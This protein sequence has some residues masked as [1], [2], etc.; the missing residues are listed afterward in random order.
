[1]EIL[2]ASVPVSDL[3]SSLDWYERLFGRP[4][5]VVPNEDEVMWHVAGT[6]WLYVIQDVERAG[7]TVVT[8]SVSDLEQFVV[9]L[10]R[11]GI[12]VGPVE[13]H[14]DAGRKVDVQDPDG[15]VI[16]WIEVSPRR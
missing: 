7:K 13:S 1:M 9:D 4:P 15:N 2:F 12:S 11:R 10:E 3:H 5:D 6:G 14:T 16:S 8:V